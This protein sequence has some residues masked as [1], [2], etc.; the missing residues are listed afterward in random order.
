MKHM[1]ILSTFFLF[2]SR[3]LGQTVP[4]ETSLSDEEKPK[5]LVISAD[6]SVAFGY[7]FYME[8][9]GS[10]Q[11]GNRDIYKKFEG[12]LVRMRNPSDAML[13]MDNSGYDLLDVYQFAIGESTITINY[14]FRKR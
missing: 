14:I 2:A 12:D 4:M 3:L 6:F 9:R 7:S 1:I 8:N 5:M 13:F 11:T 10:K